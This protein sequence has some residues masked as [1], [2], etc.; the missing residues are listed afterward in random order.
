M[1]APF[2]GLTRIFTQNLGTWGMSLVLGIV[3]WGYLFYENIEALPVQARLQI[4]VPDPAALRIRNTRWEDG[5]PTEGKVPV[6]VSGAKGVIE[7][8]A[9]REIICAV[10]FPAHETTASP[11]RILLSA[12]NFP[13]LPEQVTITFAKG[14]AL[15]VDFERR[16][17]IR[18]K[19]RPP[20]TVAGKPAEGFRF[21]GYEIEPETV[22]MRVW[23]F[24]A[25]RIAR[26]G[27]ELRELSVERA[28]T[29]RST[30]RPEVVDADVVILD[31]AVLTAKV[32]RSLSTRVFRD[33]PLFLARTAS[34]AVAREE[35]G[36][37]RCSV[38]LEGPEPVLRALNPR[39]VHAY[40]LLDP[41]LYADHL[42]QSPGKPYQQALKVHVKIA[43]D[44]ARR[45]VESKIVDPAEVLVTLHP[46]PE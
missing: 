5:S 40:V 12:D 21:S 6:T 39:M 37:T 27:V 13:D 36:A 28:A 45:E 16:V 46:V 20:G 31:R 3:V 34:P 30:D 38:T 43:D 25:A 18:A 7:V 29:N 32:Q 17:E 22:R 1:T 4:S 41:V 10:R 35:M 19:L 44:A 2:P 9:K 23:E 15:L 11:H 8:Y 26:E 14:S 33:V 42:K 24:D